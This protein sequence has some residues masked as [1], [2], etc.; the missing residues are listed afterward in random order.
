M[1]LIEIFNNWLEA[2][3][4][5]SAKRKVDAQE[6]RLKELHY[7]EAI[8]LKKIE[9]ANQKAEHNKLLKEA[10]IKADEAIKIKKL[11]AGIEKSKAKA[12]RP[13][14]FESL[15]T[16]WEKRGERKKAIRLAKI[17]KDKAAK[18][19]NV[20]QPSLWEKLKDSYDN[21]SQ[22]RHE[23]RESKRKIAFELEKAEQDRILEEKR[24]NASRP[25]FWEKLF[26]YLNLTSSSTTK[27]SNINKIIFWSFGI[28]L[29]MGCLL[30]FY[31]INNTPSQT[32]TNSSDRSSTEQLYA[33]LDIQNG[34]FHHAGKKIKVGKNGYLY[35]RTAGYTYT[36]TTADH[37]VYAPTNGG[38]KFFV[39]PNGYE[40]EKP[41]GRIISN[42]A[43]HNDYYLYPNENYGT[44]EVI[45]E[46]VNIEKR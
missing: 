35:K 19:A 8:R 10:K 21:W 45:F 31:V 41:G 36:E 26:D 3:K 33:D 34:H 20:G 11:E 43:P 29:V 44:K 14:L 39:G 16:A 1:G 13:G 25:S 6:L 46:I 7:K 12:S 42:P 37:V 18:L 23:S 17:E 32:E 2:R 5:A 40:A 24:I 28:F 4:Q 15:S 38:E 27:K 30:W 9:V 22:R